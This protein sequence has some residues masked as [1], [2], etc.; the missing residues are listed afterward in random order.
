MAEGRALDNTS[1]INYLLQ[2]YSTSIEYF[3]KRLTIAKEC[4]DQIG[5]RRAHTNLGN[6][7]LYLEDFDKSLYHYRYWTFFFLN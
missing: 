6:A 5:Q 3:D 2:D 7:Y 1:N 4:N